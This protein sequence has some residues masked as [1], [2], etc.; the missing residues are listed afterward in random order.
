MK[1]IV[2]AAGFGSRLRPHTFLVP[3]TLLPVAGK[4]I[5]EYIINQVNRCDISDL[6]IIHG[7]LGDRIREFLNG[8]YDLNIDFRLQERPL[9]LAH[10]ID[11]AIT[12]EDK[13][14]LIVLGDTIVDVDLKPV[15]ERGI[16]SIG[17]KEVADPRKFGVVVHDGKKVTKL[18]E[19]PVEPPSNLAIVGLY[20]IREARILKKAIRELIDKGIT[21]KNEYQIT[22]ALQ[23]MLNWGEP[24]ETFQVDKWFDCGNPETLLATNKYLLQ[25]NGDHRSEFKTND[26]V[27]ISPVYIGRNSQIERSVIGPYVS[28]GSG[29]RISNAIVQNSI[30]GDRAIIEKVLLSETLI[31]NRAEVVGF[32][33]Q[34]NLGTSCWIKL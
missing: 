29:S 3:K 10:A 17:V 30:V 26:S 13:D 11:L 6:T 34:I 16:T 28:I 32:L 19:K 18:V 20:Y 22:D 4:P 31:G 21:V 5:I 7:H 33:N 27:I 2:P 25:R 14:L 9:G 1:V 12:P 24:I 23:L 15:I 8:K